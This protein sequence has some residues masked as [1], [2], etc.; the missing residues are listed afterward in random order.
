MI[1]KNT[2]NYYIKVFETHKKAI[3]NAFDNTR[4]D[5]FIYDFDYDQKI[6]LTQ[7]A[8]GHII[9][10]VSADGK[11]VIFTTNTPMQNERI[12]YMKDLETNEIVF[13]LNDFFVYEAKFT[14]SKSLLL[15]R[16]NVHRNQKLFV[17]NLL[18]KKI[19]YVF[20]HSSPIEYG[21]F[22][23]EENLFLIPDPNKKSTLSVFN[24]AN[25]SFYETTFNEITTIKRIAHYKA[26]S[27]VTVDSKL[28][29]TLYKNGLHKWNINLETPSDN[30]IPS[31]FIMKSIDKIL[32]NK[33]A[34][35]KPTISNFSNDYD[36]ISILNLRDGM[37][38]AIELPNNSDFT[39]FADIIPFYGSSVI[40]TTGKI[41]DLKTK[42]Y[43]QFPLEQ[44]RNF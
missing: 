42:K 43:K 18:D 15:C 3:F 14:P 13:Q 5:S 44:Y 8:K 32:L 25:L 6:K 24:F 30:S 37:M 19:A 40:D 16:A 36:S 34:K 38:N 22:N 21:C 2:T 11:F 31:F 10:D 26:N 33:I 4:H 35:P 20:P 12:L 29:C 1:D 7:N 23:L 9:L 41:F 39:A 27:Y 17:Y 28:K